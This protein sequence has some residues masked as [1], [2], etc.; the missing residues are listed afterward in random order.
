M[1]IKT[2]Q[3]LLSSNY[4]LSKTYLRRL[5][6]IS[7]KSV[8]INANKFFPQD[9]I[10]TFSLSL[11]LLISGHATHRLLVERG[12]G[13]SKSKEVVVWSVIFLSDH[14]ILSGDSA[15]K[16]QVWDGRTGTLIR[17]HLVTKWDV[18][19][20]SVSQVSVYPRIKAH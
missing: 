18:L 8:P 11:V 4:I 1:V 2:K 5:H 19:T 14:T 3:K 12:V 15:G 13:A 7:V 20:L 16:I 10:L 9:V 17:T 6:S